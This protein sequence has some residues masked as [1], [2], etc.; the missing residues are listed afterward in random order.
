[1]SAPP[2]A[3]APLDPTSKLGSFFQ[4]NTDLAPCTPA[5]ARQIGKP[6]FFGRHPAKDEPIFV[7][8][9]FEQYEIARKG[10][11]VATT[12]AIVLGAALV[13]VLIKNKK[14][15]KGGAFY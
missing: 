4:Y 6:L 9:D 10:M 11:A 15:G 5:A 3:C 12:V 14:G 2:P 7:A 8:M 1:M 13:V